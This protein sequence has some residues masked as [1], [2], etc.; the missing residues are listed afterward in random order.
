[1]AVDK[2]VIMKVWCVV[3][4]MI[5]GILPFT[6]CAQAEK[7]EVMAQDKIVVVET[8]QGSMEF[9]LYPDKAP[10]ACENFIGLA[11]KGYYD[12]LI[13]HR[14]IKGFMVQGGDPQGTGSGGESLW[15]GPFEDEVSNDLQFSQAGILAMA[16]RGPNTNGS[17]FFITTAPTQWLQGKHTIFGEI[18]KGYDVLYK[19]EATEVGPNSRPVEEQKIVRI[20]VKHAE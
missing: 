2:G 6:G 12:G 17:Q 3:V 1:M 19:I 18:V 5:M 10:K 8:N 9:K 4:L 20:Y 14:V 16:N 11:A 7:G 13:F 15:G